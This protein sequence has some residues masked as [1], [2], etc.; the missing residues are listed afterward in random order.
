MGMDYAEYSVSVS[1]YNYHLHK[2]SLRK[3]L[4]SYC[5]DKETEMYH[6]VSAASGRATFQSQECLIECFTTW[7]LFH[8]RYSWNDDIYQSYNLKCVSQLIWQNMFLFLD[9]I[10]LLPLVSWFSLKC[11]M[12]FSSHTRLQEMDQRWYHSFSEKN[13][14]TILLIST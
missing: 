1:N 7:I 9:A 10:S 14:S 13:S 2:N 3:V 4:P 12:L 8:H 11:P 5:T 6:V